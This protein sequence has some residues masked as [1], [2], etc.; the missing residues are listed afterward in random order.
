MTTSS[1]PEERLAATL[2]RLETAL[3][4]PPIAGE[5]TTWSK[6]VQEAAA[7]L[8][9]DLTACMRS[10]W[11]VQYEEIAHTDPEMSA[12][13]E[14]LMRSDEL[15]L[16]QL[17]RFHEDLHNLVEA[18]QHV[19]KNELKLAEQRQRVEDE[20]IGLILSIRKQQAAAATWLDEAHFRDRGVAAD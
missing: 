4:S 3:L 6:T 19:T 20:G 16:E 9:V 14:K 10:V 15:V 1:I 7:T 17:T 11:H 18:A 2:T 5:L 12:H 13:V 8:A